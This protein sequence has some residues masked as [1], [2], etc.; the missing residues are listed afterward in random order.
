LLYRPTANLE[1]E[2]HLGS[3]AKFCIADA[4][5]AYLGSANFTGLG[6]GGHLEMGVLLKGKLAA[7]I[8]LFWEMLKEQGVF[9]T[10]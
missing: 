8:A 3:H 7:D 6:L 10:I 1:S 2:R 4:A 9:R 5:S